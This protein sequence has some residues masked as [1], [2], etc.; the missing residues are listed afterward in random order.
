MLIGKSASLVWISLNIVSKKFLFPILFQITM[1]YSVSTVFSTS[2]KKLRLQK[3]WQK[4]IKHEEV[5][6]VWC[7]K[8][9]RLCIIV[10]CWSLA[11]DATDT[12]W[13]LQLRWCTKD[14]FRRVC[15]AETNSRKHMGEWGQKCR[16]LA[17][18]FCGSPLINWWA[19]TQV[20]RA[21]FSEYFTNAE[22]AACK[23]ILLLNFNVL[24]V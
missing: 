6:M 23:I 1:F 7:I 17:N 15:L 19:L 22:T 4:V 16:K 14:V 8:L 2:W 10:A 12:S 24:N 9:F 11:H 3:L 5:T 18:V 21:R 20:M 13:W